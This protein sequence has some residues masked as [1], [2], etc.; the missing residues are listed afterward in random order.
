MSVMGS[1]RKRYHPLFHL[2]K[3]TLGRMLIKATD[4]EVWLSI[5]HIPFK[6]RGLSIT[7]R[8]FTLGFQDGF[9]EA[10]VAALVLACARR[11]EIR[12]VWDVGANI[13]YYSWLLKAASPNV[14][15]V[16]FEPLKQNIELIRQTIA[17]NELREDVEL[18]CAAVSDQS[19]EGVLH[20]DVLA[21]GATS[22]LEDEETFGEHNFG[23][24]S[25]TQDVR[26]VSIDDERNRR[27]RP[28]DF[29]KVDVE[30]H[31]ES[32]IRGALGT[33]ERDQPLVLI[34]CHHGRRPFADLTRMGYRFVDANQLILAPP[35]D[36]SSMLFCGF[37]PRFSGAVHDLLDE[38]RC[39]AHLRR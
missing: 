2:R 16:M 38:A 15:V 30:G 25:S 14:T 21:G 13:G 37:P 33:F 23:A 35:F 17:K 19:G 6:V 9:Q 5:P 1:I 18:V 27:G 32:A 11:L 10:N 22:T 31:E 29:L 36:I 26:L 3:I 4:I 28:V 34:E 7:H 24:P 39:L 8:P 20:T 12:S